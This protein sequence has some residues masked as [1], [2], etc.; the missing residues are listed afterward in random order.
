MTQ[1]LGRMTGRQRTGRRLIVSRGLLFFIGVAAAATPFVQTATAQAAPPP[2]ASDVQALVRRAVHNDLNTH[3]GLRFRF[4]LRKSDEKGIT[5][6]EIIQTSDGDVARLIAIGDKPLT[7]E[8]AATE[9]QRL[10]TLLAHPEMQA[11]RKNREHEDESRGDELARLLPD[12]FL[13]KYAGMAETPSGPAIKLAF[14]PN[15]NFSPPDYEARVFHGMAG[16]V[17]IDEKQERL[18]RFD[19]H[20]I[21]EVEFGWGF[22]GRLYKGGTILVQ[23]QDVGNHH[24][25]Q[26]HQRL[27]LTGKE[28]VFKDL[29]INTTEDETNYQQVP[30]NWSYKDAIHALE[31]SPVPAVAAAH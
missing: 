29:I 19:A 28:L 27:N 5:T 25:D 22:F 1:E 26:T 21:S 13:Y 24:W 17:W 14:E 15:P 2:A 12:A 23:A 7:P 3:D 16:E 18:T 30:A 20:L 4:T 11:H 10:D 31:D 6:K 8:Q 9:K